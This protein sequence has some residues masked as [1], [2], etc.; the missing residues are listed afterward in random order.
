M[1]G[2]LIIALANLLC[3]APFYLLGSPVKENAEPIVFFSGDDSLKDKI[4]DIP[5]YNKEMSKLY[6]Q[7]SFIF[8]LGAIFAF[9]KLEIG[10]I[11]LFLNV[12]LGTYLV[13][14]RYKSIFKKYS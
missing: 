11:I 9:I 10:T 13:Y 2:S 1:L 7:Y 5:S 8:L 3:A 4:K 12:I 14:K 6:K